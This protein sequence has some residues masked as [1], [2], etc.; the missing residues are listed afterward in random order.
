MAETS[1]VLIIEGHGELET[2]SL[3][4]QYTDIYDV[5]AGNNIKYNVNLFTPY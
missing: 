5:K 1:D 4:V 3:F 2:R